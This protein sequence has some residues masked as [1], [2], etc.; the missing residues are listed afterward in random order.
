[1]GLIKCPECGSKI[2]D[3]A[4]MC[5]Y[6][7]FESDD[8]T[9]AISIQDQYEIIPLFQYEI[10]EWNPFGEPLSLISSEDNKMLFNLLGKW[11]NLQLRLP[12]IADFIQKLKD[13]ETM[14][15]ADMDSYLKDLIDKGIYKIAVDKNGEI[16]P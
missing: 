15:V 2:S 6:C 11:D 1:M 14:L 10:E 16:L 12:A 7:G 5:S 8:S 13:K 4:R 9:R 3:R